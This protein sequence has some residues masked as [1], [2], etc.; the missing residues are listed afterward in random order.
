MLKNK[1]GG[2][3]LIEVTIV[4]AITASMVAIIFSGQG[5][6]V[7]GAKFSNT[8]N[9]VVSDLQAVR[10]SA[11]TSDNTAGSGTATTQII[12]GKY[13]DAQNGT[14]TIKVYNI[15][16]TAADQ[17]ADCGTLAGGETLTQGALL[18]TITLP[19][20]ITISNTTGA[21]SQIVFHRTLCAGDLTV[22]DF[23]ADPTAIPPITPS[24][25]LVQSSYNETVIPQDQATI[26]LA[27]PSGRTATIT[28]D[29]THNGAI[30]GQIQ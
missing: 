20:G 26:T 9:E 28:I 24:S 6:V 17:T 22:Y 13:I 30:T 15:I 4:L 3:T 11:A 1:S 12:F 14:N 27:D 23:S 2:F 16:G 25:Y 29:G 19:Y 10:N 5:A 8:I 18:K 7:G 21:D